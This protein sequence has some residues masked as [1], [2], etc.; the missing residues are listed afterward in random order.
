MA[1]GIGAVPRFTVSPSRIARYYFHECDRYLRYTST[2]KERKAEEGVPARAAHQSAIGKAILDGG[3][4]WEERILDEFLAGRVITGT[5]GEPGAPVH[6][7]RHDAAGTVAALLGAADGQAVYQ[8]TLRAPASF[9]AAYGLDPDFVTVVDCYPDLLWVAD[10]GGAAEVRV[11]DAKATDTAR[12]AHRIQVGLYALILDH[13]LADAGLGGRFSPTRQGG[14]WLYGQPKPEWFDLSRIIPPLETFLR[15]DLVRV[16][17][18]RTEDAFWHLSRRCEWCDWYPSCRAEADTTQNVSLMP[19]LSSFAKRHLAE[20]TRRSPPWPTSAASWPGPTLPP[21]WPAAPPWKAGSARCSLQ[22]DALLHDAEQPTGAASVAMPKAEHVMVVLTLQDEPLKGSLYGYSIRRAKGAD[23]FGKG[24]ETVSRVAPDGDEAT[25]SALRRDLVGDLMAIL[26]RVD[27]WNRTHDLWNEQKTV[28]VYVFDSYERDLLVEALLA[29]ATD[30]DPGVAEA[31]LSLLF[32]FQRPELVDADDHP[33]AEVFFPVVVVSQVVRSL[34]ALPVTVTYRLADVTAA[35]APSAYAADYQ[36][37]DLFAFQLSNRMKSDTIFAVWEEGKAERLE[38]IEAEL[39]RRTWAVTS[40][41]AGLRE[42]LDGRGALFAWPPKFFLPPGLGFTHPL[43][44]RLA[45]VARYEAVLDYLDIRAKRGAPAEERVA[46]GDSIRLT[47]LGDDRY[48]VDGIADGVDVETS[49]FFNWILTLDCESG[50]RARLAFDDFA[51]RNRSWAPKHLDLALARVAQVNDDGTLEIHLKGGEAFNAPERGDAC[52]LEPRF[53]DWL[54]DRLVGE[55]D[56]M[57]SEDDPWFLRLV[58]DPVATRRALPADA[59]GRAALQ[60]ASSAGMTKSQLEAFAGAVGHD[61][62]LVWGP[63]GTGKTHFLAVSLLALLEAAARA[64]RPLRVMVTAFTNA[65][66][67]NLLAKVAELQASLGLASAVPIRKLG[68]AG[69]GAAALG[70]GDA[71]GF[72]RQHERVVV[73]TTVWQARKV[74]PAQLAYDVVVIDEGSQLKVGESAIAARRLRPGGRLLIAGDHRQLPPVIA[75]EYPHADG[76]PLLSRSILECLV[77]SDPDGAILAALTENFRMCDVLCA[78]PASSIYPAE[79][80]PFDA[81]VAAR[82][83][84]LSPFRAARPAR[85]P[86]I[87]APTP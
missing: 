17:S 14:V 66:I 87:P 83:L 31:A 8:G 62:Q 86:A 61:V 50:R 22:V 32:W 57:D 48:R 34:V 6:E 52:L 35:L 81:G 70:P 73:G 42:R 2:P 47:A 7:T 85:A 21:S 53:S 39:N 59:V 45:F 43:L 26:G 33:A 15:Q 5:D 44:S 72:A 12:L 58:A 36:P 1:Q 11:V 69:G 51:Y 10:S 79:Y 37:S 78:Y 60:L 16:L 24:L 30:P 75:G 18:G 20:A 80:R 28:Q 63:P 41:I 68:G 84:A 65:A 13:V 49:G 4:R 27:E 77:A 54:S 40:V 74:D 82:R 71:A 29:A 9:Y 25:I 64:G 67:D 38:W 23:L 56:Q 55:L 19:A 46:S 76:E 3:F